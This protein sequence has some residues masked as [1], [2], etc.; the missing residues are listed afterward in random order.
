[1][2]RLGSPINVKAPPPQP[3]RQ[4]GFIYAVLD[5][6]RSP[7]ILDRL[8]EEPEGWTCLYR[9]ESAEA[10]GDVAPYLVQLEPGGALLRWLI[11]KGIGDSWGILA[12]SAER[13]DIL[14][15]HF[16]KFLLAQDEEGRIL[17]FRFYDP[18]VLRVFLPICTPEEAR[19]FFGPVTKFIVEESEDKL[20]PFSLR[21][22]GA[23]QD[24]PG[25]LKQELAGYL[26]AY[27]F[28]RRV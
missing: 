26:E 5:A 17:Y 25:L 21:S 23:R 12:L 11:E 27:A 2:V 20:R 10:L 4:R 19:E 22:S 14:H 28:D 24:K 3:R 7:E 1:M 6:A 9:G 13:I 8:R 16:R 15:R 18:R